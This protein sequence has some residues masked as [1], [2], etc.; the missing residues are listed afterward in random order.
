MLDR[1]N[2]SSREDVA[3]DE[4]TRAIRANRASSRQSSSHRQEVEDNSEELEE[5]T[6]D[7]C[8]SVIAAVLGVTLPRIAP[9][10]YRM[11]VEE[12]FRPQ[13]A[14]D[15]VSLATAVR[16][17]HVVSPHVYMRW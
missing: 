2:S 4:G 15:A 12:A 9:L 16:L 8:Q 14:E 6:V 10:W 13:G 3:K 7:G 5:E 11:L 1:G 17:L